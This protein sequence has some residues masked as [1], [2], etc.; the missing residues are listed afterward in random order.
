MNGVEQFQIYS[1]IYFGTGSARRLAELLKNEGYLKPLF[2]I[3][4]NLAGTPY[5]Q[6]IIERC[7]RD[8]E[9]DVIEIPADEEPT[10][11]Y[12]DQAFDK[13]LNKQF[14]SLIGIGGGSVCDLT[15]GLGVLTANPPPS[16]QYRGLNQVRNTGKPVFL[17]PSTAGT[18]TEATRTAS[19]ID[20]NE[21]KKLG[22][23]GRNVEIVFAV[24]DPEMVKT[25]PREVKI[26][27]GLDAMLHAVE[28]ITARTANLY[29]RMNGIHA[30]RL[31]YENLPLIL[32]NPVDDAPF[33]NMLHG[34]YLAGV[35]MFN[36]GGGP[37]SGIS[38]PLGVHYKVPHGIAGGIFLQHVFEINVS[39]GYEGYNELYAHLTGDAR[40]KDP[41]SKF[42][43]LFKAFYTRIGA[44]QK[45]H[46][47]G[48][49]S[50]DVGILTELT[51]SQRAENLKLNP[52]DFTENDVRA[53]LKATID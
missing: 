41:G 37:A 51:M 26:S 17:V 45:L 24:L 42:V 34:S 33:M 44:P 11:G 47:F 4:R 25:C 20:T 21:K 14:D 31:L 15:K 36:A 2:V 10:Y 13:A 9:T 53:L 23:N 27:A 7:S 8:S 46:S 48:L 29:T 40:G 35:A 50:V 18:G 1:R 30:F 32:E 22:I 38:Y 16:I 43:D 49:T 39:K 28:A 52:L 5:V 3:D 19:F 6:E 12:L